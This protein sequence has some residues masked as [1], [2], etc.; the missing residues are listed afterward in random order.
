MRKFL[1]ILL[2]FLLTLP[3]VCAYGSNGSDNMQTDAF[4]G[5]MNGW[6]YHYAYVGVTELAYAHNKVYAKADGAVFSLDLQDEEVRALS[7]LTGLSTSGVGHIVSDDHGRL[8]IAYTDGNMDI[9]HAS[10]DGEQTIVNISDIK[11]TQISG[12]SKLFHDIV[13]ADD[14]AYLAMDFGVLVLNLKKEEVADWYL[15]TSGDYPYLTQIAIEGDSLYAASTETLYSAALKDNLVDFAFWKTQPLAERSDILFPRHLADSLEINHCSYVASQNEGIVRTCKQVRTAFAPSGPA[16]NKPYRMTFLGDK[17]IMVPGRRWAINYKEDP[18]VM[19]YEGGEWHN[20]DAATIHASYE[21]TKICDYTRAAIDPRNPNHYYISS[22]AHG[23]HEYLDDQLVNVFTLDNSPIESA[24]PPFIDYVRTDG[25]VYDAQGYL[26]VMNAQAQKTVHVISP[27]GKWNSI[28]LQ[29]NGSVITIPTPGDV[30]PDN[31]KPNYK[32]LVSSRNPAGLGLLDD[33]NTPMDASDDHFVWRTQFVDQNGKTITPEEIHSIAQDQNGI[34]WVGMKE[35]VFYLNPSNDFFK[36]NKCGRVVISRNDGSVLGDYLLDSELINGIAVDGANRLWFATGGSGAF[37]MDIDMLSDEV[38]TTYHFTPENSP[39]PSNTVLSVAVHPET[40]EVFL[41]SELGLVSFRSD[42][43]TPHDDFESA[44]V[45]PNPV[46]PEY[47][48][49][50]TVTGLMA[51]SP[52]KI[53]DAAGNVVYSTKSNGGIAVWD[54]CDVSGRRVR[55]GVYVIYC[56]SN[57]AVTEA[58]HTILKVLIM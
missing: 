39:L 7:P 43:S 4:S 56:N 28:T 1:L 38:Q 9:I 5:M 33:N 24:A 34:V 11:R 18:Y 58:Q 19:I 51:D 53:A 13:F 3:R 48:G 29:Q 23:L 31:Q 35:G 40:G 57:S 37:L 12:V 36:S 44:Y 10:A 2:V 22:Y 49:L 8:L 45:Y 15:P 42:A 14:K 47:E 27:D 52:V 6:T 17:M 26:W 20:I 54:M 25:V 41:G 50:L 16:V 55:P 46:R 32:W 30:M 21:R